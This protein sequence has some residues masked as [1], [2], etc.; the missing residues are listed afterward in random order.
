L[1]GII[2]RI[3]L[4]RAAYWET[5]WEEGRVQNYMN[6]NVVT[7][8]LDDTLGRVMELLIDRHIHRV[9]AIREENGRRIPMGV[10]S[11]ADIVY[12]MAQD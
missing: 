10:L 12:H 3:D 7:V 5:D 11:A 6:P 2:T 4:V 9:V 8:R 1:K